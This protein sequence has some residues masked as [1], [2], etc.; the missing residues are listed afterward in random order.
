MGGV[1]QGDDV[2]NFSFIL[3]F[4]V[5]ILVL[6]ISFYLKLAATSLS[7]I[8]PYFVRNGSYLEDH[9]KFDWRSKTHGT[10]VSSPKDRFFG[11]HSFPFQ[12]ANPS[13]PPWAFH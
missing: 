5:D 9:P 12:M 7:G 3:F 11:S 2:S 4:G 13:L 8:L 10:N 1:E 6:F